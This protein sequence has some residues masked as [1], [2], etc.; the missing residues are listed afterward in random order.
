MRAVQFAHQNLIVHRDLKPSNILVTPEGQPKLLD[1]GIAKIISPDASSDPAD[2]T[3]TAMRLM[4]PDYASPEQCRGDAITTASD[5]YSLGVLLYVLLSGQK[6]YRTSPGSPDQ[7]AR[8]ICEQDPERPSMRAAG[9]WPIRRE[10]DGDLDAIVL[11]AIEKQPAGRYISVAALS[12]D[13]QRYLAGLPVQARRITAAYRA[14]KFV[15]RHRWWVTAAA[16][17]AC[18]SAPGSSRRP[19]SGAWRG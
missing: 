11:K 9:D 19:G 8:L 14:G 1:F 18:Q 10:L 6:P 4:T 3:V 15:R 7:L 16:V 2:Q 5:V 17:L 12:D 13:L